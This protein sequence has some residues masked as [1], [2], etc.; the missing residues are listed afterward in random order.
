V[1]WLK[2]KAYCSN[3]KAQSIQVNKVPSF[4]DKLNIDLEVAGLSTQCIDTAYVSD[5]CVIVDAKKLG[6]DIKPDEAKELASLGVKITAAANDKLG[7]THPTNPD[8][9]HIS[10]CQFAR[11]LSYENG[12]VIS[13][14]TVVIDPGKVDRSPTGTGCTARLAVLYAKGSIGIGDELIGQSIIGSEFE[15]TIVEETE[16]GNKQAIIPSIRGRGWI[17]GTHQ[18]ML[19]P[20]DPWSEGYRFHGSALTYCSTGSCCEPPSTY[21]TSLSIVGVT[22]EGRRE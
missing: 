16:L 1:V 3:G 2:I 8:W 21:N 13:H 12:M 5:S 22:Y 6:F 10:F 15:S 9:Q 7:F 14:N 20:E 17:T 11:P 4:A 18:I 19:D